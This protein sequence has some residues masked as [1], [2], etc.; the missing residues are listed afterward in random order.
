MLDEDEV[1]RALRKAHQA[2]ERCERDLAEVRASMSQLI[3]IL[4]GKGALTEGQARL[5]AKVG[6]KAGAAERP[7][8]KLRVLDDKYQVAGSDIDCAALLHLCHGRCCAFSFALSAQDLE[9]GAVRWEI[10]DPYLIRHDRDGY[11]THLD[12]ASLGCTV[13]HQRP[14]T[15][16]QFDCRSDPRVWIDFEARIPAPMPE[17][18][19]PLR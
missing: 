17:G 18:L 14:A 3:D 5:I 16:R 9:E 1:Y 15:C 6:G 10:E 13:Y 4:V 11:C 2:R 7:R 12:R 8:V 19:R